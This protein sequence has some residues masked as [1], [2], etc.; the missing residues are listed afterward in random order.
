MHE[1]IA[2]DRALLEYVDFFDQLFSSC[3]GLLRLVRN[4]SYQR[5][6]HIEHRNRREDI[7]K[8]REELFFNDLDRD[9]IDKY[10]Q[11]NL[12]VVSFD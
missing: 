12:V 2:S 5:W 4:K 1:T 11:G 9:I 6:R 7:R 10:L 8:C 3:T